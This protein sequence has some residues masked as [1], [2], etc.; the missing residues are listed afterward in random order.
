MQFGVSYSAYT[1]P[2][3]LACNHL[4]IVHSLFFFSTQHSLDINFV[5]LEIATNLLLQQTGGAVDFFYL[6]RTLKTVQM[7]KSEMKYHS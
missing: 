3:P 6:S 5:N 4:S 1:V 7:K 2:C